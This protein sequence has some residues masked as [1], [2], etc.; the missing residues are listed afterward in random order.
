MTEKFLAAGHFPCSYCNA[1][2]AV[3]AAPTASLLRTSTC[4]LSQQ[5]ARF[6]LCPEG[7]TAAVV[8]EF[9]EL[10]RAA[11]RRE[12]PELRFL[13]PPRC[14]VP[15]SGPSPERTVAML[16]E[17]VDEGMEAAE[18]EPHA[19][20][21]AASSGAFISDDPELYDDAN[22]AVAKVMTRH[23]SARDDASVAME[24]ARAHVTS[25]P[26]D[27]AEAAMG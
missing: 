8:T 10:W 5:L 3:P 25:L 16:A 15:A 23:C 14:H 13:P 9:D 21:N 6:R 2:F 4:S 7:G 11:W 24:G 22:V 17:D 20:A 12:D 26:L 18:D 19:Y 1:S 27:V